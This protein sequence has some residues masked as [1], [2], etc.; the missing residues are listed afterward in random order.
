MRAATAV[1]DTVEADR[2]IAG[3]GQDGTI[4]ATE[5]TG[6]DARAICARARMV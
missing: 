1:P 4:R 2:K 6:V 3:T 5:T